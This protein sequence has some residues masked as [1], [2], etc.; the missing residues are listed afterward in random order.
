MV[1][2]CRENAATGETVNHTTL[3]QKTAAAHLAEREAGR[4]GK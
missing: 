2:V 3:E 4:N 1:S